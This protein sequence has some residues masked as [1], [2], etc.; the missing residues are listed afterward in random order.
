M[1]KIAKHHSTSNISEIKQARGEINEFKNSFSDAAFSIAND[2][3]GRLISLKRDED[4]LDTWFSS[5][6]WPFST[7]GWPEETDEM[8]T[9]YPGDVL[10][11]AREIITLWVSRMVMMG[12]YCAGD[13]PF[14]DVF[15]QDLNARV[16]NSYV[17]IQNHRRLWH[18]IICGR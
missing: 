15:I 16:Q 12:Q 9:F 17:G 1:C 6:L 7:L 11:T 8:K 2:L 3:R 10:C 5:A 4:V 18:R 14:S 13:I